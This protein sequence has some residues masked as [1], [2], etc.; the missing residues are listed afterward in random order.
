VAQKLLKQLSLLKKIK[1]NVF[2]L[3][4]L[5]TVFVRL[6]KFCKPKLHFIQTAIIEQNLSAEMA[7]DFPESF[8][9]KYV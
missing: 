1:L 3:I 4:F 2:P 8:H 5:R 9:S 6:A 7:S